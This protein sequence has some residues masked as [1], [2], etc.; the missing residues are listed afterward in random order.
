[1]T[2]V[3]FG[4]MVELAT[5]VANNLI[6]FKQAGASFYPTYMFVLS[7][8]VC[9]IPIFFVE[10]ALLSIVIYFMSN[11]VRDAGHFFI[12]YAIVIL[13]CFLMSIWF[14]MLSAIARD[15][16]SAH[17]IAG[18][19]TGIFIMF[20]GL[21][22]TLSNLPVWMRW[23]MWISPFSWSVR[24][25]A[26]NEFLSSRYSE[27]TDSGIPLGHLFLNQVDMKI[28]K[29][30]IG[31]GAIY[32]FGFACLCLAAHSLLLYRPNFE[33]SMGTTRFDDEPEMLDNDT[34]K[35][36]LAD[37]EAHLD[38][39]GLGSPVPA[40]MG[41]DAAA[42]AL[43]RVPSSVSD[44]SLVRGDSNANTLQTLREAVAFTPTWLTFS[45]VR[46]T[47]QVK[48]TDGTNTMVD[49]PLLRGVNGYAEPGKYV[50]I[51]S[52]FNED[53]TFVS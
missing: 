25:L 7:A 36:I 8:A 42:D 1:M 17:A 4:S 18:P 47:V 21:F 30:W 27:I 13:T 19:S 44:S 52:C 40:G 51:L 28:G 22:V 49:R 50:L 39:P 33:A 45:D 14:R 26:N 9:G 29:E 24:A 38:D 6:V 31:Y 35:E 11:C 5:S 2:Q 43:G 16:P 37:D 53:F 32:L 34:D 15:E 48:A 23:M 10:S 12:F 41:E 20:G 46:Y 3:G